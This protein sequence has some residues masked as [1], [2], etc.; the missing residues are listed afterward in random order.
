MINW[1]KLLE[2]S[3]FPVMELVLALVLLLM[4][5]IKPKI[6]SATKA[7]PAL[8]TV[9]ICAASGVFGAVFLHLNRRWAPVPA[10]FHGR[11]A[12]VWFFMILCA[13]IAEE[14]LFRGAMYGILQKKGVASTKNIAVT[15]F[16]FG[17]G[18][19]IGFIMPGGMDYFAFFI[20]QAAF[21]GGVGVL[22]GSARRASGA[23][24]VPKLGHAATNFAYL[25]ATFPLNNQ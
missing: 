18:H 7:G 16:V 6:F 5:R 14:L 9:G 3:T 8:M 19:L 17:A 11:E 1:I 25:S 4:F 10:F 22:L 24:L 13:P 2:F 21:A 15:A 12:T 20:L 23:L